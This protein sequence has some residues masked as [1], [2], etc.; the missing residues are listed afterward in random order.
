MACV[1]GT[2]GGGRGRGRGLLVEIGLET[3]SEDIKRGG[4]DGCCEAAAPIVND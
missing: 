1:E 4:G 2:I 3:C